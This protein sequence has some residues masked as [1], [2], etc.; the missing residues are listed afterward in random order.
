MPPSPEAGIPARLSVAAT[1]DRLEELLAFARTEARH[2]GVGEKRIMSLDLVVEE[3]A[4]NVISYAYPDG[5]GTI[6]LSC[7]SD[8]ELFVVEIADEGAPYDPTAAPDPDT[9]LS[10][11]ER[12]VGGLGLLL[13]RRNCDDLSW[14]R[15]SGRNILSCRFIL[16]PARALSAA[17][18]P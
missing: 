14:R 2:A 5:P 13:I 8:G 10:L 12:D 3:A 9:H 6:E 18:R 7:R 16:D 11:E 4:V 1:L 15:E 17:P